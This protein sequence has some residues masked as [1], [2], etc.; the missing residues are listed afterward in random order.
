MKLSESII[1]E[2]ISDRGWTLRF[3]AETLMGMT[4]QG[5]DQMF[6]REST[7]IATINKMAGILNVDPKTL[8]E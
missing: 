2:Q 7:K 4:R 3:F 5:F 6:D 1:K 8:L